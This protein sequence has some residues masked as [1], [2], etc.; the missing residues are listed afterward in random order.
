MSYDL[1]NLTIEEKISLI[2]GANMWQTNG[3]NG[4]LDSVFLS[5]G[6]NGLRK[7]NLE[8]KETIRATA[9]PNIVNVA[10]TWNTELAFL[11]GKTI[12]DECLEHGADV[13]LAPGV[14]IKRTA[15]CGR[16]FEYFSED[17]YLAG[18]MAKAYINGVQSKEVGT[19]LKH[20]AVNNSEHDRRNVSSEVDERALREIYLTPFEIALEAKPYTVMGAYNLINGIWSAENKKLLVDI[21]RDEFGYEGLVVSDWG[22][23]HNAWRSIKN[24]TNLLMPFS[25]TYINEI[26]EGYKN[27]YITEEEIDK[28]VIKVLELIDKL[29]NKTQ[30]ANL[31]KEE[32][33]LNAL[34]IAKESIVLLKND[35]VLPLN[36]DNIYCV[37]GEYNPMGGSG[38][39]GVKTDFKQREVQTYLKQKLPSAKITHNYSAGTDLDWHEWANSYRN[40]SRKSYENDAVVVFVSSIDEGEGFDRETAKLSRRQEELILTATKNNE[41]VIVVV[42]AG[43]YVDMSNWIDKVKA[44]IFA[45][46]AGEAADEA[47]ASILA[48][49]TSPSGKLT[50]TFPYSI[51]DTPSK[52]EKGNAFYNKYN[53]GIMVGY[54]WYD[55]MDIPVMFPF[56][57]GLSYANFEYSNLKIEKLS[58]TD[59]NVFVTVK[60]TSKIKAKEVIE[61]YVKDVFS[62]VER[63]YKELKAFTKVELEGGE[64][65]T[66]KLTLD[67][68]S[69]AYYSIML[70]KWHIE[71]GD[72]EILVG[73]SSR[74]IRLKGKIDINLDESTQYTL[75]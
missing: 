61:L 26:T 72:F 6:P 71:N 27:G 58:E 75:W 41:N 34:K 53:E 28:S 17:P 47:I 55:N 22:A 54:R 43:S 66:V 50:E 49:E 37:I 46:F 73:S 11:N 32:R 23:S 40:V 24:G 35:N 42:T 39:A 56:G 7:V 62:N 3:L 5:D 70:N 64:S 52:Y 13:L 57:H 51:E 16:N 29:K 38:S 45:G 60:N 14:N 65:K 31:S 21:L 19:S 10:N 15:L 9:M 20:F 59:Y 12:A 36:Y 18:I 67:K 69:F 4:K 68:R 2:V 74:D 8:T 48:G 44:V 1:K 30:K 25:T 33:H 63:P